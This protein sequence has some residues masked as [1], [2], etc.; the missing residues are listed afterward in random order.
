MY[1][2][3]REYMARRNADII[4]IEYMYIGSHSGA[5]V[6]AGESPP[7][8]RA[9]QTHWLRCWFDR[10]KLRACLCSG[11]TL[12]KRARQAILIALLQLRKL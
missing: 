9:L 8:P 2:I 7:L 5:F 11:D 3:L 6:G 4:E 10:L 1:G 12:V